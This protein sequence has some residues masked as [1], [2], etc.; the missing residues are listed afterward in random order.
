MSVSSPFL[1]DLDSDIASTTMLKAARIWAV[2][3]F[4]VFAARNDFSGL[5]ARSVIRRVERLWY[6]LKNL[7]VGCTYA[8]IS[9]AVTKDPRFW[10]A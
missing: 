9:A 3:L 5:E 10:P 8:G 6:E 4:G 1:L 7:V 2:F